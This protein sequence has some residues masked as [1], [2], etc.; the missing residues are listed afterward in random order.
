[1][2]ETRSASFEL[3]ATDPYCTDPETAAERL[4][5]QPWKRF[6]VLGDS[7]TAGIRGPLDGYRDESFAERLVDALASTRPGFESVNLAI[8]YLTVAEI[9]EVQLEP[10]L[11]FAPD[12][13]LV[14]AGGNDAFNPYD[15]G[16]LRT[17]LELLLRPLAESGAVVLTVGLFDLAR[18]GLVRAEQA[19]DMAERFDT[20]DR[21]TA[22]ITRSLGGIHIDTH[23]HPLSADPAIYARDR[24]H[25]NARGHAVAFAAIVDALA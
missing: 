23:H 12:A 4:R 15:P 24:I 18:S 21:I 14:S 25:G 2:T 17:E 1:M 19:A 20:L 16:Q 8:P 13:V 6:A 22:E 3:E 5:H 7:V 11:A 9:R 10:A